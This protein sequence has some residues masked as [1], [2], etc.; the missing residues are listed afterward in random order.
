M[1]VSQSF[2]GVPDL[3]ASGVPPTAFQT[4]TTASLQVAADQANEIAFGYLNG[5]YAMPL[6]AW[7]PDVTRRI[8]SIGVWFAIQYRGFN[9]GAG[10]DEAI[11]MG[12]EDSIAWF[13]GVQAKRIHP[14]VT[15]SV[16]Q[17]PTY[18]QPLVIT[19][20][21]VNFYGRTNTNRGW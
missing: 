2:I 15:P 1:S 3:L 20:S 21:V 6:L 5:R 12:Y 17:S 18:D 9:P 4:L 14:N 19:S 10:S 7:G 8:V 13:T 11:R 16:N